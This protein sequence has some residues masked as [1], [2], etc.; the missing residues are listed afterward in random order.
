MDEMKSIVDKLLLDHEQIQNLIG[1][2]PIAMMKQNHHYHAALMSTIFRYGCHAVMSDIVLWVYRTYRNKG[3]D[4]EY[5]PVEIEAWRKAITQCLP[6]P[7]AKEADRIYMWLQQNHKQFM[8]LSEAKSAP[9]RSK[10]PLFVPMLD[11]ILRADFQYC[12]ELA[13]SYATDVSQLT[14]LYV[15]VL[16][17][18]MVEVGRLWSEGEISVADEHL[19]TAIVDRIMTVSYARISNQLQ[20]AYNEKTAVL[21]CPRGENHSMGARMFADILELQG[22]KVHYLGADIPENEIVATLKR[23]AP[24]LLGI[25][26]VMPFNLRILEELI[27]LV[28]AEPVL[29][30][31]KILAGGPAF[32]QEPLLWQFAGADAGA[33]NLRCGLAQVETWI[34]EDQ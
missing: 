2:N 19:F 20:V 17:P 6:E 16:H 34:K 12:L 18:C 10:H 4:Y 29:A 8:E 22:W 31:T 3:F 13:R 32:A 21:L 7:E 1:R 15:E 9:I 25:S 28:R 26:L 24:D 30:A 33:T 23:V 14:D 27:K 5:F 11:G